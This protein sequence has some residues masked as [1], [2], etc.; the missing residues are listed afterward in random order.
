MKKGGG[1][2][3][4]NIVIHTRKYSGTGIGNKCIILN[5]EMIRRVHLYVLQIETTC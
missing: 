1:F 3:T 2:K 5:I 4:N